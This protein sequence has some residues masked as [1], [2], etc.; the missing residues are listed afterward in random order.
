MTDFWGIGHRTERRLKQM[1][2][3]SIKD[4]ANTNPDLLKK[5]FGLIGLQLFF[6]A[7]G[8]DESKVI[9]PYQA[10]STGLGNAQILPKDYVKQR[11]IEL[12]LSEMAEQVAIRLRK[13]HR[14]A[15]V[16]SIYIGFSRQERRKSISVQKKIEPSQ[17]SRDLTN[18]VLS[19]F[20]KNYSNGAV[21]N[22]SVRYDGLV[23]ENYTIL[24]LFDDIEE[25]EKQERLEKTVDDIRDKF[26]YLSIQKANSLLESSRSVARSKL[27]GG[28]SAGG[29]DGLT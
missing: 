25:V 4:L 20:R 16:V 12:V 5:E 24:S 28:H 15:T 11:D 29:L 18:H 21:R 17:S 2:I 14:K 10:K 13:R 1:G 3:Y 7:N 27:I 19:L 26:G 8:V 23:D 22:I 9:E 6:H